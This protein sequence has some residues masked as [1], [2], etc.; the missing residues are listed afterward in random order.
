MR[1]PRAVGSAMSRLPIGAWLARLEAARQSD[2]SRRASA[3]LLRV[4]DYPHWRVPTSQFRR[5]QQMMSAIGVSFL[6]AVTPFLAT[7]PLSPI[8]DPLPEDVTDWDWLAERVR[9]K[10]VEVG[11][12]GATHR[13]RQF[14]FNS[15]FDD[16]PP[17]QA[18]AVIGQAWRFLCGAGCEPIAFVPPFNRF[19]PVL[20]P[21]LPDECRILCLGPESL[22]DV[23][24]LPAVGMRAGRTVVFSLPPFYGRAAHILAA[25][26]RG[27]LLDRPGIVLPIT[28]HWT[29]ELDD[30][31]AAVR[32]LA[33]LVALRVEPWRS[34][35]PSTSHEHARSASDPQRATGG[36][37]R[38][39]GQ[40]HEPLPRRVVVFSRVTEGHGAGGMQ[41]HL[42]WLVRWLR[43]TGA[44]VTVVTT[45]GGALPT[46][47]GVR[48]IEI[49][50]TRPGRYTRAWWRGTSALVKGPQ[51]REWDLVLS[52]DGGAWSAIDGLRRLDHR[53]P[54][55]MFR[56]G[57]TLLNL[58]Q[59][60][61]PRGPRAI[62]SMALSL[63]DWLRHP[64][65]LGRYV[66]LML[67]VS[68]PVATSAR[69]EGAGPDTE[70]RVVPLGVDLDDF[71]PTDDP[72]PVRAALGLDP[73]LPTLL[74]VGRDVPGKRMTLAF[75]VF[76]R[77]EERSVPCQL[78]LA[79]ASPRE[80]TLAGVEGLRRRYG[81]RVQLFADADV[82][83]IRS[84]EQAA[85]V[86]LFPSVLP[87]SVPIVILEAL[88]SGVPV[89]ATPAGSLPQLAVFRAHPDWLVTPDGL[90]AWSERAE[91]M[92]SGAG[93]ECARREARAIAERCYDLTV[94]ARSTV[95]AID[96]LAD[97]WAQ[98]RQT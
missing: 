6:L 4:D 11:L 81:S 66:D 26:E 22:L 46:D 91:A 89:L 20:W 17:D 65:R 88:A 12:H 47:T 3:V 19:P 77:L 14:G 64:R 90:D 31:F 80:P 15:E 38:H 71:R 18:R 75:D 74:W 70:I 60:L 2:A 16:M 7:D 25:L 53:P 52:E 1:L 39:N 43:T 51:V 92:M 59:T 27:E 50:G 35:I 36:L 30:D 97:R 61:P 98:A 37:I 76:S 55:V 29:W 57:T 21:A 44:E 87:E 93:A 5:F 79:V 32:R 85:S 24:P 72:R 58:R 10:E 9:R 40:H 8:S 86:L 54:I 84:L 68:E 96:Q 28:L 82:S 73:D 56:H 33:E 62:G 23:P 95:E 67:C 78:A 94:T 34:L 69:S 48:T 42:T 83:R 49:P 63:R 45:R 13:T 41:R